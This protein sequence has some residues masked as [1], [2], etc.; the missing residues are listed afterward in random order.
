[1]RLKTGHRRAKRRTAQCASDFNHFCSKYGLPPAAVAAAVKTALRRD[2]IR[3]RKWRAIRDVATETG[4]AGFECKNI[5]IHR[6][7]QN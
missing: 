4:R 3:L 2:L 5:V 7:R 1:M 6:L